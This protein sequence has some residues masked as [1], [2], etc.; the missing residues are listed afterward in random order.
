MRQ[1]PFHYTEMSKTTVRKALHDFDAEELRQLILDIYDKSKDAKE[2]LDFYAV[3]DIRAKREQYEKPI[4]KEVT[5]RYKRLSKPRFTRIRAAVKQFSRLDVGPEAVASLMAFAV[6]EF[7]KA[8]GDGTS[9]PD[10]TVTGANKFLHDTLTFMSA[11]RLLDEWLPQ[12]EK[13][14]NLLPVRRF[15]SNPLHAALLDTI[16]EVCR[17]SEN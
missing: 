5:R 4:L 11:H 2:L 3:P 16:A 13:N 6:L 9:L 15:H 10:A 17:Q 7:L 8:A 14:V 12:I 1:C